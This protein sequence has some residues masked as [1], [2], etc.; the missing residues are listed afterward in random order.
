MN[1]ASRLRPAFG[2]RVNLFKRDHSM[3]FD[4]RDDDSRDDERLSPRDLYETRH[5]DDDARSI[6]RGPGNSRDSDGEDRYGPRDGVRWPDRDRDSRERSLDVREPFTRDLDLPR[7]PERELARDRDR[8]YTLR[9]SETRTLATVGAFRVVS[10][11]DR[12]Q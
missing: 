6:G 7:G 12:L 5:R 1:A 10:S 11:G 4:P 8:A 9:G 2:P 3:D